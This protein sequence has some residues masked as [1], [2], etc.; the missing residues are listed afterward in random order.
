MAYVL[1]IEKAAAAGIR[2][3]PKRQ[4]RAR[5]IRLG[6]VGEDEHVVIMLDRVGWHGSGDLRV[7]GKSHSPK[8]N[9]V[10]RV[11]LYLK[12][13]FLSHRLRADYDAIIEAA[14][15]PEID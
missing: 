3:R 15:N 13:C 8:L 6:S 7:P 12:E 14:C 4:P 9:P 11:W 2:C 10:E 1:R 5:G